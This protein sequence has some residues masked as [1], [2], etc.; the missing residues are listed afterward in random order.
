MVW[1]RTITP[2]DAPDT[3]TEITVEFER[4]DAVG[5]NGEQLSPATLLTGSTRSARRTASAGST[6][7][8]TASSA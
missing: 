4:G 5:I 1:Q 7:W 8:R 3:P 2:E 6:W